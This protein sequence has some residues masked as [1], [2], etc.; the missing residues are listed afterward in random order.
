MVFSSRRRPIPL[1]ALHIKVMASGHLCLN[2]SQRVTWEDS[3]HYAKS[4]VGILGGTL[5]I[6]ADSVVTRI[7]DVSLDAVVLRLVWDDY[8]S[9]VSLESSDARG[10]DLVKRLHPVLDA[11]RNGAP[12]SR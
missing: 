2:L 10:D 5:K 1:E 4:L 7:W 6:T 11:F 3:S 12:T 8:P 9:M